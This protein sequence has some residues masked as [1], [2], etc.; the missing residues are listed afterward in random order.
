MEALMREAVEILRK[1]GVECTS[2]T[3]AAIVDGMPD[4]HGRLPVN[5]NTGAGVEPGV[6]MIHVGSQSFPES[7]FAPV[8][9]QTAEAFADAVEASIGGAS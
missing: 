9:P 1:R 4:D 7:F 5:P 8:S 6:F 3:D 2:V